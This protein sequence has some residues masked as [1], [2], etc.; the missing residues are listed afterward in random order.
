MDWLIALGI[1]TAMYLICG[2]QQQHSE[3]IRL[4]IFILRMK[5]LT[6]L[7]NKIKQWWKAHIVD[8]LD[9]NNKNF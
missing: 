9:P 3:I 8:E 6:R 7:Q 4:L 5:L 1:I 2:Q